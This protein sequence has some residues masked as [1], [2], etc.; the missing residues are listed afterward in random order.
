MK[1]NIDESLSRI[2]WI[3]T[4]GERYLGRD[5]RYPTGANKDVIKRIG[6]RM[7][8]IG[9]LENGVPYYFEQTNPDAW[10]LHPTAPEDERIVGPN[11]K[12]GT[13]HLIFEAETTRL[14]II[15][16]GHYL[17]MAIWNHKCTKDTHTVCPLPLRDAE[18]FI[19]GYFM[20]PGEVS[21]TLNTE[22]SYE[23]VM[24]SR[25]KTFQQK[26]RGEGNPDLLVDSEATT[27]EKAHFPD[28]PNIDT[29]TEGCGFDQQRYDA[30]KPWCVYNIML[31]EWKGEVAYRLG[32]GR[33]HIDAW[34]QA[35]PK[36][37]QIV[38]G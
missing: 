29:A 17:T 35:N 2:E 13:D 3:E 37:K 28:R 7:Q 18:G 30:E 23:C 21:A 36:R 33:M 16:F 32:V 8:W 22:A 6:Y 5:F 20:V 25:S 14:P 15:G 4:S 1:C 38:L 34:A 27:M 31:V 26:S 19:G 9:A 11:L 24:I 10:F 12:R